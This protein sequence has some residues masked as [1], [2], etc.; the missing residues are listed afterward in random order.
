MEDDKV[1]VIK[2]WKQ[3]EK[4]KDI[5]KFS[6]FCNFYRQFIKNYTRIAKPLM[7]L[8]GLTPFSWGADQQRSFET[9]RDAIIAKLIL[10]LPQ[11]KG[12]FCVKTDASGYAIGGV[13]S[14]EQD[15]KWHPIVFMSRTMT[16]AEQNYEIYDKELLAIVEGL[17]VWR[18]YLIDAVEKFEILMEH[19][20]LAY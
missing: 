10:A 11:S 4:K 12:C 5:Q 17:K 19:Q 15:G 9:L 18:Q 7:S 1:K 8:T 14:Q 13:L 16:S 2:E 6:G 20:N 3:P